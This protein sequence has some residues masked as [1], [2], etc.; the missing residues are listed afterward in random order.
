MIMTSTVKEILFLETFSLFEINFRK[1][2]KV[3]NFFLKSTNASTK[4]EFNPCSVSLN[5]LLRLKY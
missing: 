3:I 1:S 4:F 5:C 2:S